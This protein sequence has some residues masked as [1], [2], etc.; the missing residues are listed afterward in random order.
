MVIAALRC[1]TGWGL[2]NKLLFLTYHFLRHWRRF[3][4]LFLFHRK[5]LLLFLK[6]C[7]S[8][9][10]QSRDLR[11]VNLLHV[12]CLSGSNIWIINMTHLINLTRWMNLIVSHKLLTG[13]KRGEM[14]LRLVM[15]TH[16]TTLILRRNGNLTIDWP[17][18][19]I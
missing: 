1:W 2:W 13:V 10:Q 19:F 12:M 6:C 11:L 16:L 15:E 5:W 3:Q 17:I 7:N 4:G 9:I 14:L 8:L 18:I